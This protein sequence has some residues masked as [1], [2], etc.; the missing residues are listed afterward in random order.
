MVARRAVF[1]DRDDT[2]LVD[3][4]YMNDPARVTLMP[5]TRD[6][7]L[8]LEDAG[9]S[10]VLVSN[11]SGV[12]RGLVT[13][14]QVQA[15]QQRMCELLPG[16]RFDGFEYCWH[17]PDDGC[18]CRKPAP[19]MILRAAERLG[20]DLARSVMV[21]DKES[22]VAAGNNAGCWTV[23]LCPGDCATAADHLAPD[24]GAAVDWI[25]AL[26]PRSKGR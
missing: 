19:T 15:I 4:G 16:I 24:L 7:L 25:L 21:G 18:D 10:L 11:Q 5:G 13:T 12:A 1:L 23:R 3:Q 6:A 8:R 14:E 26:G 9:L 2:L 20:I 17:H 22:D